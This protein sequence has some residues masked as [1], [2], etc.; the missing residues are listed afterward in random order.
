MR[1]FFALFHVF[2]S[3]YCDLYHIYD[4]GIC[5]G[6][7]HIHFVMVVVFVYLFIVICSKL[8]CLP[9]GL[10]KHLTPS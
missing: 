7:N 5:C 4:V 2:I 6:F 10:C 9:K 1:L 8:E 3:Y